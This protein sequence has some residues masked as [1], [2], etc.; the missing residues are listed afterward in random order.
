[1]CSDDVLCKSALNVSLGNPCT[2]AY[3]LLNKLST[4][5]TIGC[6]HM[7]IG[8]EADICEGSLEFLGR[9]T[10]SGFQKCPGYSA[11]KLCGTS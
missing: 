9:R 3:R 8:S 11:A 5:R 4:G 7:R 2:H 10:K 1:M 6:W